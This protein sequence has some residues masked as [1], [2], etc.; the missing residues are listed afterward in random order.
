MDLGLGTLYELKARLLAASLVSGTDYDVTLAQI[1]KGVAAGFDKHCNRLFARGAA[2]TEIASADRDH[3]YLNRYPVESV[4]KLELQTDTMTGWV[5]ITT[6]IVNTKLDSGL[7]YF[8]SS[9]GPW[10]AQLRFT[11]TGGYFYETKEPTDNGYPTSTP[12]GATLLPADVK[13]AWLRQCD[14][15]WGNRDQ[16]GVALMAD[17]NKEAKIQSIALTD[18]VKELLQG[19]VRY[20]LT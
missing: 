3:H 17:P 19:H 15:V 16:L 2:V 9:L 8:G 5:E 12:S 18:D 6:S 4:T 20:A 7:V 13:E 14:H 10:Y 1:G 11:Y